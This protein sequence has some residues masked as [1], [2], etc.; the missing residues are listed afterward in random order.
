MEYDREEVGAHQNFRVEVNN[1]FMQLGSTARP[2]SIDTNNIATYILSSTRDNAGGR[3]SPGGFISNIVSQ[4]R[5]EIITNAADQESV[6]QG[7]A[8]VKIQFKIRSSLDLQSATTNFLFN[9]VISNISGKPFSNL[10]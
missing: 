4:T 2:V 9:R 5:E 1:L 3:Q 8:G 6:L 10:S 7:P